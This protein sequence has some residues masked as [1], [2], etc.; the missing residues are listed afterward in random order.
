MAARPAS[1]AA[2]SARQTPLGTGDTRVAAL[3]FEETGRLKKSGQVTLDGSGNGT[4]TLTPYNARQRWEVDQVVVSTNQSA[5]STPVPVAEVFVNATSSRGNSEGGTSS[6]SQDTL[7]GLI[8]VGSVD[9]LSI[10]WTGGISGSVATAIVTGQF[11]TR[12]S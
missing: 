7:S 2:P 8:N 9:Q 4:V 1:R 10:V 5:T 12:R 11:Y 3:P 6:G